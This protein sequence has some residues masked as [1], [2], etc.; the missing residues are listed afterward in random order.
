[1]T[2]PTKDTKELIQALLDSGK[3]Y[4]ICRVSIRHPDPDSDDPLAAIEE[5]LPDG[6]FCDDWGQSWI[7]ATPFD[8]DT[9]KNIIDF[10]DGKAVLEN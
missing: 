6:L 2:G 3:K 7:F 4:V 10:V 1:M 8:P 5:V 9:G